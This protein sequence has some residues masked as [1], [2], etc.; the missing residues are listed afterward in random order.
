MACYYCS[1]CQEI[2]IHGGI[3][4]SELYEVINSGSLT[5]TRTDDRYKA[6]VG[7][8]VGVSSKYNIFDNKKL[9]L[10][11]Q[12]Q[13]LS[14]GTKRNLIFIDTI[15]PPESTINIYYLSLPISLDYQITDFIAVYIGIQVGYRLNNE[16]EKRSLWTDPT[17]NR[18]DFGARSGLR[19][20]I[21][22]KI[23]THLNFYN[24][25]GN[26]EQA[27]SAYWGSNNRL[28]NRYLSLELSYKIANKS[29]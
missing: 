9:T 18:F 24:G 19:I 3:L 5:Y 28:R 26:V 29:I 23:D 27:K 6:K 25:F 10:I 7:Y 16:V 4:I 21:T 20:R 22:D 12:V 13:F 17:H 2:N 15:D 11:P 1:D 14:I 8:S